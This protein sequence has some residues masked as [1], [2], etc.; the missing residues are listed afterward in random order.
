MAVFG[1]Q[2]ARNKSGG[3][4]PTGFRDPF[5]G[6]SGR[7]PLGMLNR[8]RFEH[9]VQNVRVRVFY[10]Y[11]LLRR[12]GGSTPPSGLVPSTSAWR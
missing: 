12:G 11:E 5:F 9:R 2:N 6:S 8:V 7:S 10:K 4:P 3:P 1:P